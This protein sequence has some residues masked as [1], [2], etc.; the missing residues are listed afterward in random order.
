MSATAIKPGNLFYFF[1]RQPF[2]FLTRYSILK[3]I[4]MKRN[5]FSISAI[6]SITLLAIS[7]SKDKN[8]I[9]AP[10]QPTIVKEWSIP[11]SAKNENPAPASRNETGTATLQLLSD[12]SLKYSITVTGLAASDAL[13]AAHI[14]TG[15]VITNGGVILGFSPTFS[16]STAS[17]T[18]TNVRTTFVDSLKNDVNELYFNVHSTQVGSGLVRGQLNTKL[19]MTADVVM[20]GANEVQ[21]PAVVT[22]ATGLGLA[23]LTSNKKLYVK[24][25]VSGLEANDALSAAHIHKGAAGTNGAILIGIYNSAAEFGTVKVITVDDVMFASLKADALYFNAHSTT[26]PAGIIRG[27]IR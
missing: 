2:R 19:E 3:H 8:E 27:Q 9:P 23:R 12:N 22:N 5:F 26:K 15:D 14:H 25:T 4:K 10:P 17:G 18:I 7:C 16:G 1:Q 13:T 20:N 11:L 21:T 6:V 24:V